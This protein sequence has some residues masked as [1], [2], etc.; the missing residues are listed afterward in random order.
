[1]G[2]TPHVTVPDHARDAAGVVSMGP[3]LRALVP[4]VAD[5]REAYF[6]ELA[7]VAAREPAIHELNRIAT[8]E[9][10]GCRYCRNIRRQDAIDAGV[11]EKAVERVRERGAE[12][13]DDDR[14]RAALELGARLREFPLGSEVEGSALEY[15][16]LCEHDRDLADAVVLA[17]TRAIADGKAIVGLGL[18][19]DGMPVKV[20]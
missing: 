14:V 10:T 3:V 19:P 7:R 1:M 9:S 5:L 20:V 6:V 18:E 16:A 17:V 13:F 11:D 15:S 12:G 8:A 2:T 4:D